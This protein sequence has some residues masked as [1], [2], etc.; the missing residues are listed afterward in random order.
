MCCGCLGNLEFITFFLLDEL[1]IV[2]AVDAA[3][4][5]TP[6]QYW[7]RLSYYPLAATF[8]LQKLGLKAFR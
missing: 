8:E 5:P 1:F 6:P 7:S 3:T 2:V 4:P